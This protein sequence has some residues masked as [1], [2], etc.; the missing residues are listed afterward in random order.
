MD[1][2]LH[3]GTELMRYL[4]R[5]N[6]N[7]SPPLY[8]KIFSLITDDKLWE[9]IPL[10]RETGVKRKNKTIAGVYSFIVWIAQHGG[11]IIFERPFSDWGNYYLRRY[12][13]WTMWPKAVMKMKSPKHTALHQN[14]NNRRETSDWWYTNDFNALYITSCLFWGLSR[15]GRIMW[16]I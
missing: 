7:N 10:H 1:V 6:N 3:K 14:A 4:W 11:D 16:L 8:T 13:K 9:R 2:L 5:K 15:G 12:Y